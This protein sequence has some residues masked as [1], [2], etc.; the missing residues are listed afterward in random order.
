M[1]PLDHRH[2][3][4][5]TARLLVGAGLVLFLGAM[6]AVILDASSGD[7]LAAPE[8]TTRAATTRRAN[9]PPPPPP[10]PRLR[11][12]QLSA[13]A[14]YDPEGDGVEN[15]ELAGAAVDRDP[16]T[17][18][19]TERYSRFSKEGVGIV[20]D[21]QRPRT[22]SRVVVSTDTPG[23]RAE[24][25]V[26]GAAVGPYRTVSATRTV[27]PRTRFP[28]RSARGRYLLVWITDL[29][30]GSAANVSEVR[31]LTRAS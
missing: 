15:D 27:T 8:T 17:S 19:R 5:A 30:D 12:V 7:K 22:L 11:A 29:P 6:L 25:R 31:A 13:V 2:R 26:A 28:L 20:F 21:A 16:T 18:W 23:F 24:I 4:I 10:A 9:P 14:A 3:E 1:E